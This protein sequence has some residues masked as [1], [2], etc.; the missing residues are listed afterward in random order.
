MLELSLAAVFFL[1]VHY[2]AG[3]KWHTA[4]RRVPEAM[5]L[6][7]P[8]GAVGL[9]MVL[10]AHPSLYP[11][12]VS[13]PTAERALAFKRV[14]L[15]RPFFLARAVLYL[16]CW[17][18]FARSLV[19]TS[20]RQDRDAHAVGS[21]RNVATSAR[22]LVVLALTLVPASFDW[23][24]S[25]EPV[26][27]STIFGFYDFAGM[28]LTGLAAMI[29]LV[30]WV[31]QLAAGRFTVSGDQFKDLGTLL[32]AF[33]TFW[34]YIWFCQYMLIWYGNLPEETSYFVVRQR[35]AW[36]VLFLLNLALNW[37]V[38]FLLLLS[39]DAKT[40]PPR[41][42]AASAAVLAGRFVDLY[43]AIAPGVAPSPIAGLPEVGLTLGA[44]G[45]FTL[46]FFQV[47]QRAPLVPVH[48]PE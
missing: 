41:L 21:D 30:V 16:A 4:I 25:L 38:P 19:R 46:A 47:L 48:D 39:R 37:A 9:L 42:L 1:A 8:I 26:W 24:M 18:F 27:Y 13:P 34:A 6:V 40:R 29:V 7:L 11:W 28:F 31:R 36:G 5:A 10:L 3:A 17:T 35:E 33:S 22:F 44:L 45:L 2:V 20:Y 12:F 43:L 23:I 15:S 14:W 32:F